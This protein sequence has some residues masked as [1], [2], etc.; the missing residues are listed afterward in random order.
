MASGVALACDVAVV[1]DVGVAGDVSAL[2]AWWTQRSA[3]N[4]SNIR[5]S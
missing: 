2:S 5:K 1:G 3:L 4:F